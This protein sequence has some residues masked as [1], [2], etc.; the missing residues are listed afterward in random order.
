MRIAITWA[1]VLLGAAASAVVLSAAGQEPGAAGPFTGEQAA[2]GGAA[3]QASCAF[4]HGANLSGGPYAPPL[5]GPT[6]A[7]GWSQ[8]TT[9]DLIEAIR[10]MPPGDPGALGDE[11]HVNMAAYILQANG[12]AFGATPLTVTATASID[13]ALASRSD[14]DA[15]PGAPLL[16]PSCGTLADRPTASAATSA[17]NPGSGSEWP[18]YGGTSTNQRFS[19]LAKITASNVASLGGAWTTRLPGPT[20]QS[21]ITMSHGRVFAALMN[22]NVAAL[23]A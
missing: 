19:T 3:F 1:G 17:Q 22:C 11:A 13:T 2:A 20:N 23:D 4:C 16:Q 10:T 7:D 14:A 18:L 8:R 15:P 5:A 9:L 21:S 6:F 12:V